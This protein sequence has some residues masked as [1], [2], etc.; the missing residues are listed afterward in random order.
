MADEKVV[1][2]EKPWS[3]QKLLCVRVRSKRLYF[4]REM[5]DAN[6]ARHE[7]SD[8]S[9][10]SVDPGLPC[11]RLCFS[12]WEAGEMPAPGSLLAH[13]SVAFEEADSGTDSVR[14]CCE[15][16]VSAASRS[17]TPLR[18][19]RAGRRRQRPAGPAGG[20]LGPGTA[21]RPGA[22]SKARAGKGRGRRARST[23][24]PRPG[25]S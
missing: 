10:A 21:A 20:G 3:C 16:S 12:S 25:P 14:S 8:G 18:G 19:R 6:K 15:P 4:I 9:S 23:A 24:V 1:A 2:G 5:Q 7:L 13:V 22:P 11:V 17:P